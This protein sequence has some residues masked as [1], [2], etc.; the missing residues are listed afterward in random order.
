MKYRKK[1]L[2]VEAVQFAGN[3]N[4]VEDFAGG[5]AEFRDGK[6]VV[7]TLEG[8]LRAR[9]GDW[10]VKGIRGELYPVR[11]DIFEATYEPVE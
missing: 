2:V 1:P 6:L 3:F 10:I 11:S 9:S 8:P 4:E 5:D 7:A